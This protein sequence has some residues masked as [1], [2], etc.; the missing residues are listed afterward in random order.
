MGGFPIHRL[1]GVTRTTTF[2]F[3]QRRMVMESS[4][5]KSSKRRR[6]HRKK[7]NPVITTKDR[8]R[9]ARPSQKRPRET[10]DT[11]I[12]NPKELADRAISRLQVAQSFFQNV[13]K[14]ART[15]GGRTGEEP[16]RQQASSS[17]Q[18]HG[19]GLVM[20]ANWWFWN[21]LLAASPA[22][23]IAVYCQFVVI[24]QMKRENEVLQQKESVMMEQASN[25]SWMESF[26]SL[27]EYFQLKE[28][29]EQ[30]SS[31]VNTLASKDS[32][33]KTNQPTSAGT[34]D[35]QRQIQQIRLQLQ[36]L[37][38]LIQEEQKNENSSKKSTSDEAASGQSSNMRQR[39]MVQEERQ[40]R[41]IGQLQMPQKLDGQQTEEEDALSGPGKLERILQ[42]VQKWWSDYSGSVQD[43]QTDSSE[44][45][46]I[47]ERSADNPHPSPLSHQPGNVNQTQAL[48][49]ADSEVALPRSQLQQHRIARSIT[50]PRDHESEHPLWTLWHK[51]TD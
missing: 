22:I 10:V 29:Q 2:A 5:T 46:T 44:Q 49:S 37:E 30:E 39:Y 43:V 14:S 18:E 42:S 35:L 28:R 13:W 41:R 20:D 9:S 17:A 40:Q 31:E 6:S 32:D 51:P 11:L 24:P 7:K 36:E 33:T 27:L 47:V 48:P 34:R 23:V 4:Q 21:L 38:T 12:S 15:F 26:Q 25:L 19:G 8:L 50:H 3:P 1:E 45:P 16:A